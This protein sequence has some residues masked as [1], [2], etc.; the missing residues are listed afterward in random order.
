M[1]DHMGDGQVPKQGSEVVDGGEPKMHLVDDG[2]QRP[3]MSR[4]SFQSCSS[5]AN[6]EGRKIWTPLGFLPPGFDEVG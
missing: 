1:V 3:N 4:Q 6:R 5:Y 2:Y